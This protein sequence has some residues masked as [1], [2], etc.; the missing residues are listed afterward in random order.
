MRQSLSFF[1]EH[2]MVKLGALPLARLSASLLFTLPGLGL[3][4]GP[5]RI[6]RVGHGALAS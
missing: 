5:P 2:D 6:R 1:F 4:G 3:A